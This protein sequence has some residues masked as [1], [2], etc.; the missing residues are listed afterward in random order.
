MDDIVNPV[1]NAQWAW[2]EF[3]EFPRNL[4]ILTRIP[5]KSFKILQISGIPQ[6]FESA[7]FGILHKL[8]GN[9]EIFGYP[10]QCH[11]HGGGGGRG[12]GYFM[13]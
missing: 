12:E 6:D 8:L 5:E 4:W 3:H 13:E 10:I 11:V 1:L 9:L 7:G 2:L